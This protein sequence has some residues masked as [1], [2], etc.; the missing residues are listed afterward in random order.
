MH[1][2]L[3]IHGKKITGTNPSRGDLAGLETKDQSP[4]TANIRIDQVRNPSSVISQS[5]LERDFLHAQRQS[6]ADS[7]VEV[8]TVVGLVSNGKNSLLDSPSTKS[9][10][11]V[12]V[13]KGN[14]ADDKITEEPKY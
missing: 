11:T 6:I 4:Q 3:V 12:K 5:N 1:N 9:K 8:G 13:V 10:P 7:R 14:R 2:S